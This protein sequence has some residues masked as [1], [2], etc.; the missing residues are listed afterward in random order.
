[1]IKKTLQQKADGNSTNDNNIIVSIQQPN[2]S[3]NN[4]Y[5]H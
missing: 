1:M 4:E 3:I 5:Q 2:V